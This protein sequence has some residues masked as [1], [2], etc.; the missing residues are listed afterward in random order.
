MRQQSVGWVLGGVV[1]VDDGALLVGFTGDEESMQFFNTPAVI[2]EFDG[3][4]IEKLGVAWS[5]ALRTKV[6]EGADEA[7]PE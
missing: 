7:L 4:P 1:G 6:A 5:V 3:E 2:H